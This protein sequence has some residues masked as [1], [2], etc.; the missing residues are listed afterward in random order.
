MPCWHLPC[1]EE[2]VTPFGRG[3]RGSEREK[4]AWTQRSRSGATASKQRSEPRPT[5]A[6]GYN[7]KPIVGERTE[8][9]RAWHE[10]SRPEDKDIT[11]L[12]AVER[13][14]ENDEEEV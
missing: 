12:A 13:R 5:A 4:W 2:V 9:S 3:R 1:P 11:S 8:R 10:S 7:D 6:R 14:D